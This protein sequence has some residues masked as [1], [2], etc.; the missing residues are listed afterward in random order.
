MSSCVEQ[1]R[2]DDRRPLGKP[3]HGGD[4]QAELRP[5]MGIDEV[6]HPE[7]VDGTRRARGTGDIEAAGQIIERIGD[8]LP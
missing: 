1:A 2:R 7:L 4:G 6:M 5:R 3:L 8:V